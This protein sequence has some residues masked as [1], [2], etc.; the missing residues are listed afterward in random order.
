M[1]DDG[2]GTGGASNVIRNAA[3][4]AAAGGV[5]IEG[6]G[7]IKDEA[8]PAVAVI[9]IRVGADGVDIKSVGVFAGGEGTGGDD[10]AGS[11][12]TCDAVSIGVECAGGVGEA[13]GIAV[14]AAVV[15][16]KDVGGTVDVAFTAGGGTGVE[17][18]EHAVAVAGAAFDDGI[19][20]VQGA[21]SVGDVGVVARGALAVAPFDVNVGGIKLTGAVSCVKAAVAV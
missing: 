17:G 21:G 13:G 15:A 20:I 11:I 5:G 1:A 16:I 19:G 3:A 2:V 7:D 6:A 8:A 10:E 18:A 14:V 9:I 4:A 12:V